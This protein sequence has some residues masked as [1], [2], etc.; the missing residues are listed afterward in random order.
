M[1]EALS[2]VEGLKIDWGSVD[3]AGPHELAHPIVTFI[4]DPQ[5][6]AAVGHIASWV[7]LEASKAAI[8]LATVEAIKKLL[9]KMI[10][11]QKEGRI[12]NFWFNLT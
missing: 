5:V 12:T 8:G 11:K 6:H 7:A 10:P 1:H 9:E 3:D 4:S 2:G